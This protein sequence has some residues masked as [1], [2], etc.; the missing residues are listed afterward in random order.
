MSCPSLNPEME[1]PT[2]KAPVPRRRA[3]RASTVEVSDDRSTL[4]YGR[5]VVLNALNTVLET[6]RKSGG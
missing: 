1:S 6:H 3:S 5:S 2:Y 4:A